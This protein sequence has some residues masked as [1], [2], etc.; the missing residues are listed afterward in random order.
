MTASGLYTGKVIHARTRPRRH[1]LCYR[2]FNLFLDLDEIDALDQRLRWFSRGRFNLVGFDDAD[3]LDGSAV[4]LKVQV[5]ALLAEAGIETGNGAVRVMCMPRVLGQV[6][7]PLSVYFCHREDGSVAATLY[8]VNNTF[9]ERHSY[10]IPVE[11]GQGEVIRQACSK[12]FYVSPFLPMGLGYVFTIEPPAKTVKIAIGVSDGQGL[13]LNA[14]FYARRTE[15]SD[16]QI[17]VAVLRAPFLML[18]VLAAI[19]WEGLLTWLK[20][21]GFH[22]RP[23]PPA[24]PVTMVEN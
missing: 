22:K 13:V 15:L 5:K 11:Y 1:K 3:H 7:N 12:D 9:G 10:L 17:L 16:P 19:H 23:K 6:F 20:G 2:I 14:G 8:E 24:R 18:K 4:P 21:S